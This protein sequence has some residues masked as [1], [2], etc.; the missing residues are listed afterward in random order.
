MQTAQMAMRLK[1]A[2]PTIVP[3]PS[4]PASKLL[5]TISITDSRISAAGRVWSQTYKIIDASLGLPVEGK[6]LNDKAGRKL[7]RTNCIHIVP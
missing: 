1:A 5:P 3:G 2:E 7:L 4:S 6:N